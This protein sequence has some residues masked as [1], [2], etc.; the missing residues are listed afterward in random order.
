MDENTEQQERA[1]RR[2]DMYRRTSPKVVLLQHF[3]T[4]AVFLFFVDVQKMLQ[5]QVQLDHEFHENGAEESF[6][7]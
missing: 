4:T 7:Q 2:Y 1:S 3:L 5:Q 6:V